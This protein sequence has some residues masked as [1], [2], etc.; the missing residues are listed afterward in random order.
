MNRITTQG[1]CQFCHEIVSK[2]G[3][4]RHLLSCGARQAANQAL[5]R[6]RGMHPARLL[7]VHI[8]GQDRPEYW[9][10][11]EIPADAALYSLDAFLRDTWLECCGHMSAFNIEGRE[12][13]SD[14][15]ED[16]LIMFPPL[17][18]PSLSGE[19]GE[20]TAPGEA[21]ESALRLARMVGV[22]QEAQAQFIAEFDQITGQTAP[23][24]PMTDE[25]AK[26][27]VAS[28]GR[29]LG[30]GPEIIAQMMEMM[31]LGGTGEDDDE[32]GDGDYDEAEYDE[33]TMDVPLNEVLRPG[34][35][36]HHEYDFGDTTALVLRVV[37]EHDGYAGDPY[38]E[39]EEY[40]RLLARNEP[41]QV[42]C[43]ACGENLAAVVCTECPPGHDWLC[44]A[45]AGEHEHEEEMFLPVVNSPRVGVCAYDG[46]L[47][48]GDLYIEW[49]EFDDDEEG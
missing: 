1:E 46:D 20:P 47:G 36:F 38:D 18:M 49:D 24:E 48:L 27:I 45:C 44:E 19:D 9:M 5:A 25:Q 39:E 34:L 43:S 4:A 8:E 13:I 15:E 41:P 7:H 6:Q 2:S 21:K 31:G 14:S 11:V 17:A 40:V 23:G 10:E 30:M 12:Y 28:M 35:T 26:Q 29:M 22:G 42:M 3:M 33:E 32:D 16:D 37:D